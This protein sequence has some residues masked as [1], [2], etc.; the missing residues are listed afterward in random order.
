MLYA[1]GQL[2]L[3]RMM[4]SRSFYERLLA[5]NPQK[6]EALTAILATHT[7]D[8]VLFIAEPSRIPAMA[9]KLEAHFEGKAEVVQSHAQFV[10]VVPPDVT[11]GRA[12]AWLADYLHAAQSE[13]LAVG[14]QQNDLSMLQWAGF[15]VAM[16]NAVDAVKQAAD[17]IAPSADEDGVAV[18]LERWVLK[19]ATP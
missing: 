12:L 4:Y 6:V 8:K 5:P 2:Y 13:V 18:A 10:E 16:A 3:S 14:D 7:A 19:G 15:G 11:K 9:R 1:D 17:W